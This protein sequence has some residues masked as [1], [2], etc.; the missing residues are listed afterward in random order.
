[1][2]SVD[3]ASSPK[4]KT[5]GGIVFT[6]LC[7]TSKATPNCI[8]ENGYYSQRVGIMN[9]FSIIMNLLILGHLNMYWRRQASRTLDAAFSL[10]PILQEKLK[11]QLFASAAESL[12][13]SFA[14]HGMQSV[15]V[16]SPHT[17]QVDY[18]WFCR[19]S[20]AFGSIDSLIDPGK[21]MRVT[22]A[23]MGI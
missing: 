10:F 8:L 20:R 2:Q 21:Q 3:G 12:R 7:D 6:Q 1:M 14:N 15:C 22:Q 19:L 17:I 18:E 9:S 13:L 23:S 11:L 5:G 4:A 16:G